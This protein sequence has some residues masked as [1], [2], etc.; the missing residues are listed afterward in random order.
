VRD[1]GGIKSM[2]IPPDDK[3]G[4]MPIDRC[5][6]LQRLLSHTKAFITQHEGPAS[7]LGDFGGLEEEL[8]GMS[9]DELRDE[10]MQL[11]ARTV[12][13]APPGPSGECRCLAILRAANTDT[14]LA[15]T[16]DDVE[17]RRLEEEVLTE[18]AS[19]PTAVYIRGLEDECEGYREALQVRSR[20]HSPLTRSAADCLTLRVS[21]VRNEADTRP[22]RRARVQGPHRGEVARA[23]AELQSRAS[24]LP[25][26]QRGKLDAS[27]HAP[28]AQLHEG[29]E[30]DGLM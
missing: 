26:R 5:Q 15:V 14:S 21:P 23:A 6:E 10:V 30:C 11:R 4:K 13:G 29:R 7:R 9:I 16:P 19:H 28:A 27:D 20:T 3:P 12:D 1:R 22:T 24:R 2:L 18:L 25:G 8:G 17:R